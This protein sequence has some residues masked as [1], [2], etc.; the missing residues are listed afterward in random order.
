[1]RDLREV[2][3]WSRKPERREEFAHSCAE[4][5]E[6]NVRAAG[7]AREC[8]EGA[9]IV[10]TA[11]SSKEPVVA[12]EWISPGTHINAAGSNWADRRE[13]PTDL[14]LDHN[15]LV[16]VDSV[17]VGKIESGDL[18]IP[19]QERSGLSFPAVELAD[20]IAGKRSGRTD[21]NQ[22]TIFKSNGL[23]LEDIA[24]AGYVYGE[25]LQRGIGQRH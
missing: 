22:I 17:E 2:R 23:A 20:I 7:T 24:V 11:T 21:S 19:L 1:M 18:L 9:D 12:A 4:K 25:A 8:V 16:A 6:L 3:V 10:V 5:F 15:A 13:L 14:I